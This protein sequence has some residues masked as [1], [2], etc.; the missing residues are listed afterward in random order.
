MSEGKPVLHMLCG[1][2]AAG[3]STLAQRL[4]A[5]RTILIA[6][7]HWTSKLYKE[8][9]RSVADYVRLVPRLHDA[10]EPHVTDLLRAG[11]SVVMDW[12]ANTIA[13]RVWMRRIFEL[14]GAAHQL[15]FLDVPDEVCLARLQARNAEGRHE[16]SVSRAEFEELSRYFEPPTQ[17]EGFDIVIH[18]EG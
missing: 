18:R 11:L 10:M 4:T 13:S 12:P 2:V 5:P 8:E 15:H 9:L 1:K 17:A 6:Q 14:V 3:K 16:Y 7:D